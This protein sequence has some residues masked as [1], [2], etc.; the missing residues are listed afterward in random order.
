[1]ILTVVV[2]LLLYGSNAPDVVFARVGVLIVVA[3]DHL[4]LSLLI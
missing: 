2:C 3:F 4:M 1:M